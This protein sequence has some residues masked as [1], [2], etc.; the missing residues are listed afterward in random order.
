MSERAGT[1][2]LKD[3]ECERGKCVRRPPIP[4]VPVVDEIQDT[5]ALKKELFEAVTLSNKTKFKVRIW[6]DGS[7]PEE[8]LIHVKEALNACERLGHFEDYKQQAY[9]TREK[10]SRNARKQED[11]IKTL[12]EEGVTK[13]FLE[14]ER[15]KLQGYIEEATMAEAKR[16]AAPGRTSSL[17]MRT[18]SPSRHAPSGTRSFRNRLEQP[19]GQT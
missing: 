2:G 1:K 5:L 15:E 7:T 11:T 4:Y 16:E 6:D 13:L 9:L 10:A 14:S 18:P 17:F 8:F 19:R 3:Q 12:K